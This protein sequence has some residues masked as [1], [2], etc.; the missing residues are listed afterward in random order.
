MESVSGDAATTKAGMNKFIDGERVKDKD[1]VIWYGAHFKHHQIN[2]GWENH[3]V[4]P[5]IKR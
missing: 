3:V 2:D 5:D 1:M 4:G